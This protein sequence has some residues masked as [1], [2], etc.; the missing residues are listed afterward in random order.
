MDVVHVSAVRGLAPRGMNSRNIGSD[1]IEGF[2]S[3]PK[4]PAAFR[5]ALQGVTDRNQVKLKF[6]RDSLCRRFHGLP[7]DFHTEG[8]RHT[9]RPAGF[10]NAYHRVQIDAQRTLVIVGSALPG[11]G[12][13][14]RGRLRHFT[15]VGQR[16]DGVGGISL[17][18]PGFS[19]G[20]AV[21]HFICSGE[22][23]RRHILE[24]GTGSALHVHNEHA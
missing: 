11:H 20:G 17:F 22:T 10:G 2:H 4:L 24:H 13:A 8:L 23:R 14:G 3:I 7:E 21:F 9:D 16:G 6:E 15:R 1:Y 19:Q 12:G 5:R 18:L